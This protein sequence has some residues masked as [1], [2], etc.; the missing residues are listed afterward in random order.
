MN[1]T[2]MGT[3]FLAGHKVDKEI[4]Q[5]IRKEYVEMQTEK[6]LDGQTFLGT[7]L[8]LT[9]EWKTAIIEPLIFT[10]HFYP[11]FFIIQPSPKIL[12]AF[13]P[14][15]P[16]KAIDLMTPLENIQPISLQYLPYMMDFHPNA[17]MKETKTTIEWEYAQ[18][19]TFDSDSSELLCILPKKVDMN[20]PKKK[21]KAQHSNI[22]QPPIFIADSQ[23][24][25]FDWWKSEMEETMEK[26]FSHAVEKE[27]K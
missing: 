19:L 4:V 23:G 24:H 6:L 12:G 13:E 16:F 22:L 10:H 18:I 26:F 2:Q 21:D 3:A 7:A 5:E 27:E 11:S 15:I 17:P 8:T 25:Q 9:F 1:L 14:I 20:G